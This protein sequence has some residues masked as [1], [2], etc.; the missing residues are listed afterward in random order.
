MIEKARRLWSFNL[1]KI[2]VGIALLWF[3]FSGVNWGMLKAS[4]ETI[5]IIGLFGVIGAM[6]LSLYLKAIRSFLLMKNFGVNVSFS[7]V[8]EALLLGQTVNFALPSRGGDV[9]RI[10]Y[11]SAED[12]STLP[13]S[14]AAVMLEKIL[15]LVALTTISL[16]ISAYLPVDKAFWVRSWLLPLSILSTIGLIV[17]IFIG[18]AIWSRFQ[19]VSAKAT[20]NWVKQLINLVDCFIQSSRWLR[21]PRRTFQYVLLTI[22]IWLVMWSTNMFLFWVFKLQV[23]LT[24]GGLV[25]IL[26][27]IGVLPNLMP[28]NVGPFYFFVQLG[29]SPFGISQETGLAYTILLH[30]IITLIPIIGC[31]VTLVI[32]ESVRKN[33]LSLWKSRTSLDKLN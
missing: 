22:L 27:Y 17:L 26:A 1:V 14:T 9:V 16:G 24:A 29:M 3:S 12:V 20:H 11:M 15:D 32:S 28:G 19:S 5:S 33:F 6:V 31:G 13:H 2:L 7:R 8:A 10:G 18:P 4:L 23:P 25:L 21:D 30:A